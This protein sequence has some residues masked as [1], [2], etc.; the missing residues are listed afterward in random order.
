MR[1]YNATFGTLADLEK[2]ITNDRVGSLTSRARVTPTVVGV[3]SA[4]PTSASQQRPHVSR[5]VKE[6]KNT[7]PTLDAASCCVPFSE[8]DSELLELFDPAPK[9]RLPP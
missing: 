8:F 6:K 9:R 2:I 4:H 1:A 7:R 5:R 3:A